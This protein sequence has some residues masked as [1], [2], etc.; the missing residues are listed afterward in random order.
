ME[1][2]GGGLVGDREGFSGGE[3]GKGGAGDSEGTAVVGVSGG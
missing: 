2:D 1:E 3:G